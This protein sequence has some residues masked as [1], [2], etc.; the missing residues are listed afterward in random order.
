MGISGLVTLIQAARFDNKRIKIHG[1]KVIRADRRGRRGGDV[2]MYVRSN[3]KYKILAK[4]PPRCI[5]NYLFVEISFRGKKCLVGVVYNPPRVHGLPIYSPFLEDFYPRYQH[6]L[7][8]GDFN[9]NMLQNSRQ[10][11]DLHQKFNNVC[12]NIVSSEPT[13]FS[14]EIPTLLDL[15]ATNK[16]ASF[17][18]F[19]QL[20]PPGMNTAHDLIYGAYKIC[21]TL[22]QDVPDPPRFYRN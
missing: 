14:A 10:A 15:C 2:A 7:L 20:S 16:P 4:S 18:L 19:T 8:L 9:T 6:C 13:N 1:F 3:I 22:Q 17:K 12:L 21:D 5:I 11:D